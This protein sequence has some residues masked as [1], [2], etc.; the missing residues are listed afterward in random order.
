MTSILGCKLKKTKILRD[1]IF[2]NEGLYADYFCENRAK[3]TAVREANRL[4]SGDRQSFG[5]VDR[6][7]LQQLAGLFLAAPQTKEWL[8]FVTELEKVSPTWA[9]FI[10]FIFL[11]LALLPNSRQKWVNMRV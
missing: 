9:S 6:R 2:Y 5:K 7:G 11:Y 1:E 3:K 8:C 4:K 10:Y